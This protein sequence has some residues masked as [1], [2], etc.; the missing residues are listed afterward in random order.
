[1]AMAGL[2]Q[3]K[4]RSAWPSDMQVMKIDP[5]T[6]ESGVCGDPYQ[7]GRIEE[8]SELQIRRAIPVPES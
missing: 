8:K 4:T 6:P 5:R 7:L 2:L 1:M 3:Q